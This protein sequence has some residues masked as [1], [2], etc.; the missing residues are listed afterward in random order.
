MDLFNGGKL[1]VCGKQYSIT[2]NAG[3]VMTGTF[4]AIC[5]EQ[6]SEDYYIGLE[7]AAGDVKMIW[8]KVIDRIELVE[9]SGELLN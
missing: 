6:I 7:V 8:N 4:V 3:T 2:M 1:M 9:V 5:Y